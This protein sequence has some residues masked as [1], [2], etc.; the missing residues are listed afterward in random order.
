L[1]EDALINGSAV[2][3]IQHVLSPVV[4]PPSVIR[5]YPDA[6]AVNPRTHGR[7]PVEGVETAMDDQEDL[8]A[9]VLDVRFPNPK[10]SEGPPN[11]GRRLGEDI[12]EG[13]A[14]R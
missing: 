3:G 14:W 4:G 13:E 10:P 5:G 1:V 6:D 8:L 9:N 2:I 12:V 7:L 11:E